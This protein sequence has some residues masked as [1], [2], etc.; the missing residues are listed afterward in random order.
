MK[1]K[2]LA[3][4]LTAVMALGMGSMTQAVDVDVPDVVVDQDSVTITKEYNLVGE[5]SS[6]EET[7]KL[8]SDAGTVKDGDA[9]T[10]PAITISDLH[11]DK[12]AA[13]ADGKK[14]KFT[15][16]LPTYTQ[17][18]VYEYTLKEKDGE[19][20]GVTYR[21][22]SMKL[23]VTVVND[24]NG[25]ARIAAVHTEKED[26]TKSDTF[27]E[28]T[29][30]ANSL[31][32]S[33]KVT[34]NLGDKNKEFSF[35]VTFEGPA[36]KTWY[37]EITVADGSTATYNNA[38][39]TATFTLKDGATATFDNIPAGVTYTVVEDDYKAKGYTTTYDGKET[40]T[41]GA[42]AIKTTVTNNKEKDVDTGIYLDNLPYILML[43]VVVIAAAAF[44]ISRK[45]RVEL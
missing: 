29:Y 39:H 14:G 23:V 1:K 33:K 24:D 45:R 26:G 4:G 7:F 38:T 44:V 40:G 25:L 28:N 12:G 8:T 21:A 19:T 15:V 18:G 3:L 32:V 11:F 16:T 22:D 43:A 5:G 6:P 10:V 20:A 35:T 17:T 27:T 42:E 41:M 9:T 2:L 31:S 13:T 30:T 36:D 37:D 34:G